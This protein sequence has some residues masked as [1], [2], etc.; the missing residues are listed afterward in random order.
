MR[1][2]TLST[3]ALAA[4]AHASVLKRDS[5]QVQTLS[6]WSSLGCYSDT[7]SNRTLG[8]AA[9][10]GEYVSDTNCQYQC[11]QLGYAYAGTEYS[12]QC[13]CDN[14]INS[15]ASKKPD[16][17]CNMAC[18]GDSTQPCGGPDR[19]NLFWNGTVTNAPP[20]IV[21][22]VSPGS[23]DFSSVGCYT[24]DVN[25]RALAKKLDTA[26]GASRTTAAT[27]I[28]ACNNA[29][30]TLA[31]VEYGNECYCGN[32]V[33]N[34]QGLATDQGTCNMACN[35]DASTLCGG[36][37]RMNLYS[38]GDATPANTAPVQSPAAVKPTLPSGWTALGCYTDNN[39]KHALMN[40]FAEPSSGMTV[41]WCISQCSS[42]GFSI[43]GVEY[44]G[45]C[46]CDNAI[47]NNQG[48]AADGDA[49]CNMACHGNA[50]ET[51]GG[52]DRLS[53]YAT[54]AGWTK[55]GCYSD[56]TYKRTLAYTGTISGDVTIE[57]CQASC[58]AGGYA[59]AG[60]EY[61]N[62]CFCGSSFNNGG[63]LAT[64]GSVGCSFACAGNSTQIC[65]GNQRLSM[66]AYINA[67]GSIST[68]PA[69]P[70]PVVQTTGLPTGWS[71]D[72]C[73]TDSINSRIFSVEVDQSA[74]TPSTCINYCS[75]L[76]YPVAGIEYGTQC[77]CGTLDQRNAAQTSTQC[78]MAC[79]GDSLL[80][81]GGPGG[82]TV[83]TLSQ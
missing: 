65:G 83:Y 38:L 52:S 27:C 55:L 14:K 45:E 49:G 6:G 34:N 15:L 47:K 30:Y 41:E 73:Y 77:Y 50:G 69:T 37:G 70:A 67:D 71:Y 10:F 22:I 76:N 35:G 29:N 51:C 20:K 66:Y 24:D 33:S 18:T 44:G 17:D 19:L 62:E 42:S 3:L 12:G 78:S 58:Q 72:N 46:F 53:L 56:Q 1:S 39:P 81:C 82:M 21:P 57:K 4:V 5:L 23:G 64:D 68:V 7:Q 16:S 13:Y 74:A 31:G 54:G 79:G 43:A 40:Y 36:P 63:D 59:Y 26:G 32:T 2:G 28:D 8:L 75:N 80:L 11:Q 60:L 61:G 9:H 25:A 48:L